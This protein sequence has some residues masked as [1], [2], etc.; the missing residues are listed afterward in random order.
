MTKSIFL[1]ILILIISVGFALRYIHAF[2]NMPIGCDE[3][4]Y[5]HLAKAIDEGTTFQNHTSRP[6][7]PELLQYLRAKGITENEIDFMVTPHAYHIIP[8]TNKVI[9]QYPPATSIVLSLVSLPWRQLSFPLIAILLFLIF[10]LG[11]EKLNNGK[12]ITVFPLLL[13]LF[14]YLMLVS[15]PFTTEFTR[16]N[17]LA[18]TFGLLFAGG[19]LLKKRPLLAAF[20]IALTVNFRL[21]N[22]IL[23]LPAITFVPLGKKK[24]ITLLKFCT[25]VGLAILPVLLYTYFQTGSIFTSTYA[26]IDT[27]IKP[28]SGIFQNIKF[29]FDL[30]QKWLMVHLF[31]LILLG[32]LVVFKRTP[33]GDFIKLL[34]IAIC[35]YV[36]FSFH[37]VTMDYYP[38]ASA[39]ILMGFVAK[40]VS[41]FPISQKLQTISSALALSVSFL[42]LATGINKFRKQTHKTYFESRQEYNSLCNYDIVWADLYSGTSE[43]VCNNNGFRYGTSTPRARIAAIKFL[44]AKHYKQAILLN[45][46]SINADIALSEINNSG[47]SFNRIDD[48]KV[49]KILIIE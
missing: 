46:I 7:L 45:D 43:Y 14:C 32:L 15:A 36:F 29:Y 17:S 38:Y 41:E 35:N 42:I 20:L 44:Q 10:S 48:V 30:N 12:Q 1:T 22:L 11:A 6:Y 13:S 4:G 3:F 5:L 18:P 25:V 19:M 40:S 33:F 23:I 37:A 2:E 8:E 31:T 49:G 39:M 24:I 21:G 16:I 27:S 9:N 47:L 28:V 26:T 34:C